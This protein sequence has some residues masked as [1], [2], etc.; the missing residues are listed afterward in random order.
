MKEP[1]FRFFRFQHP[2][3]LLA[4]SIF[5]TSTIAGFY[6]GRA[7]SISYEDR[8]RTETRLQ[9]FVYD[10][11]RA[12]RPFVFSRRFDGQG[13][14]VEMS[15]VSA[16]VAFVCGPRTFIFNSTPPTVLVSATNAA[17]HRGPDASMI[18]RNAV[19]IE[20]FDRTLG[21]IVGSTSAFALKST[22]ARFS[23]L[24]QAASR[25]DRIGMAIYS[26]AASASGFMLGFYMGYSDQP[27]C[28]QG[29][30]QEAVRDPLFWGPIF[31]SLG[32]EHKW[33]FDYSGG[34]PLPAVTSPVRGRLTFPNAPR[35]EPDFR[36]RTGPL[37]STRPPGWE[38]R[39]R[40]M[41]PGYYDLAC[42]TD[43]LIDAGEFPLATKS[44]LLLSHTKWP[45]HDW[46][47]EKT[48][49]EYGG[50][51]HSDE[52]LGGCGDRRWQYRPRPLYR[53]D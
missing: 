2:V 45:V 52:R 46:L 14:L 38:V 16:Q 37:L 48:V 43:D 21:F 17:V 39:L 12:H 35:E 5:V 8:F 53:R 26:A 51:A 20:G 3:V 24:W 9:E 7:R 49:R 25:E 29:P 10:N 44:N 31:Q 30:F 4:G 28:T 19:S 15:L 32:A 22:A 47:S 27:Q 23:A 50:S 18:G 11:A 33:T 13:R 41:E 1:G 6:V 34:G 40:L 42:L 36:A